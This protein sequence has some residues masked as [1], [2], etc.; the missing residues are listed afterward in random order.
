MKSKFLM[1]LILL[2]CSLSINATNV[3]EFIS[4]SFSASHA[5]IINQ[6]DW[7]A[8]AVDLQIFDNEGSVIYS[9]SMESSEIGKKKFV[10]KGLADGSYTIQ[11]MDD[12]AMISQE[13]RIEDSVP[14]FQDETYRVFYK[15]VVE[16]KGGLVNISMLTLNKKVRTRLYDPMGR[17]IFD[18]K[19]SSKDSYQKSLKVLDPEK[20]YYLLTVEY[21]NQTF[22]EYISFGN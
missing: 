6:N 21:K 8:G 22:R 7:N 19:S 11:W 16:V 13:L 4:K 14:V 3:P 15:P 12:L 18:E 17:E 5:F 2:V 1:G 9:D 20:G 10:T